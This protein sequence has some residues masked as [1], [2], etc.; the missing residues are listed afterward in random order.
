MNCVKELDRKEVS[1][2][3]KG[4]SLIEYPDD[5]VIFDIETTGLNS[6]TDEIIE[7]GAI[8]VN[9]NQ[10][11]DTF[12]TLIKPEYLID[13][14][15]TSLTGITN[16]MVKDAPFIKEVLLSF[17]NFIDDDILI[18]HNVNFDI[19]FIYDS[20]IKHD[21]GVLKNNFV[22]TLRLSRKLLPDLKH[23]RLS[24]LSKHYSINSEGSHRALKDTEIT[25]EV[26][27]KLKEIN[28]LIVKQ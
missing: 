3:F 12:S 8:K 25:L 5:F 11:V 20:L 10:I 23:H 2:K 26:Y 16:E 9:N 1:R 17:L 27:Y 4:K 13:P 21:L 28:N 22:D 7:I 18:G 15:I 19:N 24:D 14:F 6:K